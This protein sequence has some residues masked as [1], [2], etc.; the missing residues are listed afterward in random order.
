M[1]GWTNFE[2]VVLLGG[3]TILLSLFPLES[4]VCLVS[5]CAL[6]LVVVVSVGNADTEMRVCK[7][8]SNAKS[9]PEI[10]GDNIMNGWWVIRGDFK[11]FCLLEK[12]T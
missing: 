5:S 2:V 9:T 1:D 12:E 3:A 6:A 11:V 10:E 8:M 7:M 4:E